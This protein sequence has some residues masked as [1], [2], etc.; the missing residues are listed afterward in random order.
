MARVGD[1]IAGE[2]GSNFNLGDPYER[3]DPNGPKGDFWVPYGH[4]LGPGLWMLWNNG[5]RGSRGDWL[6]TNYPGTCITLN[7]MT[8]PAWYCVK[9]LVK[10]VHG[11][12]EWYEE[13]NQGIGGKKGKY[14]II[15]RQQITGLGD[16]PLDGWMVG[17]TGTG[18]PPPLPPVP[19]GG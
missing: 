5:G 7:G 4:S 8:R 17:A 12:V 1:V 6:L 16:P 19:P 2:P 9:I 3:G 11:D 18:D 13:I 15:T 10:H 14:I